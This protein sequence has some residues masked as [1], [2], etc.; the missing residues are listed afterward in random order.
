M[1]LTRSVYHHVAGAAWYQQEPGAALEDEDPG[2]LLTE[3]FQSNPWLT[4]V[5]AGVGVVLIV[6]TVL[7]TIWIS[8]DDGSRKALSSALKGGALALLL[9]SPSLVVKIVVLASDGVRE[10]AGWFF[11]TVASLSA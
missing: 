4:A 7:R 9:F 3:F 11:D 1:N 2:D 6:W 10:A 5:M 8:K